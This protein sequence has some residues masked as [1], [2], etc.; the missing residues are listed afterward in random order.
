[1]YPSLK[2]HSRLLPFFQIRRWFRLLDPEK[3]RN[4]MGDIAAVRTVRSEDIAA[5]DRLLSDLGFSK[6]SSDP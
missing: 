6:Q 1:M 2:K 5:Y 3:R 4:A